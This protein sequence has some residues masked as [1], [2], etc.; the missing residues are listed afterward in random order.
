MNS[1]QA[2]TSCRGSCSLIPG[3]GC[4]GDLLGDEIVVS[5]PSPIVEPLFVA[6]RDDDARPCPGTVVHP[7]GLR[8]L[9]A[10]ILDRKFFSPLVPA[11]E[12]CRQEEK[13]K[14][15]EKKRKEKK[16]RHPSRRKVMVLRHPP[17]SNCLLCL[18][19]AV[20]RCCRP[21]GSLANSLQVAACDF[22]VDISSFA[23]TSA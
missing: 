14:I 7:S 12:N 17:G 3:R 6:N 9:I 8:I 5:P 16:K 11:W 19:E 23:P 1:G 13:Q 2:C 15:E 20:S 22:V 21:I 4:F 18:V 10:P